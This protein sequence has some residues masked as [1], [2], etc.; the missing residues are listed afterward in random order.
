[1]AFLPDGIK[2]SRRFEILHFGQQSLKF[3][4]NLSTS[5]SEFEALR[6]SNEEVILEQRAGPLQSPAH[7]GL[8]EQESGCCCGNAFLLGNRSKRN[9]KIQISL[10]QFLQ[11]HGHHAHYA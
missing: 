4:E 3:V 7:G 1:M 10:T 5:Q 8:T 6:R 2:Q 9:Q 11:T